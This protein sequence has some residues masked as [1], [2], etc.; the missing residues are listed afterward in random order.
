MYIHIWA[1]YQS[2]W[3]LRA[4]TKAPAPSSGGGLAWLQGKGSVTP[5]SEIL[6]AQEAGNAARPLFAGA[7]AVIQSWSIGAHMN[8]QQMNPPSNLWRAVSG[9]AKRRDA[10]GGNGR[11]VRPGKTTP[12]AGGRACRDPWEDVLSLTHQMQGRFL[13][14]LAPPPA[15]PPLDAVPSSRKA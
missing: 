4:Q 12:N 7:Q 15:P 6:L 14:G 8:W 2:P 11:G 9:S 3:N 5:F 13:S 10:S 1:V